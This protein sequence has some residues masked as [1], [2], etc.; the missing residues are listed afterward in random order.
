MAGW[1]PGRR[2][3]VGVG[4]VLVLVGSVVVSSRPVDVSAQSASPPS[5]SEGSAA[6]KAASA[7]GKAASAAPV[8]IPVAAVPEDGR[9][10]VVVNPDGSRTVRVGVVDGKVRDG[11]G[12]LVL[13]DASLTVR[14]G[15]LAPVVSGLP[16]TIGLS[17]DSVGGLVEVG[18]VG[19]LV[20]FGRPSA[21]AFSPAPAAAVVQPPVAATGAGTASR[22]TT[23]RRR[24]RGWCR[25][26]CWRAG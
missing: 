8:P 18:R 2:R 24:L 6:G 22:R 12:R 20:R 14:A 10:R 15:R 21:T 16:V 23:A 4:V 26:R 3:L 7:A 9:S 19:R 5:V 17:M 11:D 13:A 1:V 25:W